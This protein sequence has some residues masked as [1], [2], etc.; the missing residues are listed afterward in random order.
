MG[1]S[2]VG[3]GVRTQLRFRVARYTTHSFLKSLRGLGKAACVASAAGVMALNLVGYGSSPDGSDNDEDAGPSRSPGGEGPAGPP[4]P[5]L[6]ARAVADPFGRLGD[7]DDEDDDDDGD[8]EED[9]E[10]DEREEHGRG[11][12][13]GGAPPRPPSGLPSAA[14]LFSAVTGPPSFLSPEA[15]R[16]LAS[17]PARPPPRPSHVVEAASMR[18]EAP[19]GATIVSSSKRYK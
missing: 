15:T 3:K 18:R 9:E 19:E 4:P 17:G 2:A 12:G 10:E 5:L 16:Q 14:D 1:A 7:D 11:G 6:P 8:E 13:G